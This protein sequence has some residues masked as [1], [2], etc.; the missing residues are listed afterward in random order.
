MHKKVL[1]YLPHTNELQPLIQRVLEDLALAFRFVY[2]EN[3]H[4]TLHTLLLDEQTQTST[5]AQYECSAMIFANFKESEIQQISLLLKA[6]N[7]S[8][9]LQAILTPYNQDWTLSQLLKELLNEKEYFQVRK[10][11]QLLLSHG[12]KYHKEAYAKS[13][14]ETYEK[15]FYA[16]Y[17]QLQKHEPLQTLK[18]VSAALAKAEEKLN[19]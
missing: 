16:A 17:E 10:E 12:K 9:E 8:I 14:W 13:V 4:Q 11:I 19:Q 6:L 1:I 7:T 3:L 18:N 5:K 15:S 2:Q